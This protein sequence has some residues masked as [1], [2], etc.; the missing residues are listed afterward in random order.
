MELERPF[1][2][3]T[4]VILALAAA[5]LVAFK[6]ARRLVITPAAYVPFLT[7]PICHRP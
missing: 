3:A 4:L 7:P 5:Y 6:V 2:L 1:A